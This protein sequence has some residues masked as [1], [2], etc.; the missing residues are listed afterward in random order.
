MVIDSLREFIKILEEKGMLLRIKK[1]VDIRYEIGDIC[2]KALDLRGPALLFENIKGYAG[3]KLASG[4]LG[5]RERI[6]LALNTSVNE[7]L[8]EASKRLDEEPLEPTLVSKSE[9][10]C[11]E[12]IV[13]D[14]D[15]TKLPIPIWHPRDGGPY[16]T[17]SLQTTKNE[18]GV[19]DVGII[20]QMVVG[21]REARILLNPGKNI[22]ANYINKEA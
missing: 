16:I 1:P 6:A 10:P 9:A 18:R 3:W 8:N 5:T 4:I 2:R 20:R 22:Y 11:K 12:V 19:R 7:M 14:P 21:P 13:K 17:F 15:L